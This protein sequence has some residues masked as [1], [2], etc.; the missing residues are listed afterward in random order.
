MYYK[1]SY[2]GKI[3][4]FS[5]QFIGPFRKTENC[6]QK[7][8]GQHIFKMNFYTS[9]L[10]NIFS[11]KR[12]Q[13]CKNSRIYCMFVVNHGYLIN[14]LSALKHYTRT[15][16]FLRT[17][18]QENQSNHEVSI[19]QKLYSLLRI[20]RNSFYIDALLMSHTGNG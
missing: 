10:V 7:W 6:L 19:T 14:H 9:R 12:L 8:P 13:R 16:F 3:K 2:T 4:F 11:K 1:V 18:G 20:F 17:Y 15:Q 5:S